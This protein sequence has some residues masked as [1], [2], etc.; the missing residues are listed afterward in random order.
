MASVA[1]KSNLS[2]L[3]VFLFRLASSTSFVQHFSRNETN[4]NGFDLA[5][6]FELPYGVSEVYIEQAQAVVVQ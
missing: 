3:E 4:P 5:A 1:S 2:S 6:P